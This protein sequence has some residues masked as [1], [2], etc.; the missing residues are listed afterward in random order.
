M[1][2]FGRRLRSKLLGNLFGLES[3]KYKDSKINS[4]YDNKGLSKRDIRKGL[5]RKNVGGMWEEIGKLQLSF[6]VEQGLAPDMKFLDL[7]CGSLRGGIHFINYLE[8]G[9]YYGMDVNAPL[10]EAGYNIELKKAGLTHK[11]PKTNLIIEN[12]FKTSRF[13]ILFDYALAVSVFTHLPLNHIRL[14]FIE[15]SKSMKSGGKFY[16]TFFECPDAR[17]QGA[18]RG[19][20]SK[21]YVSRRATR[22][23]PQM[24]VF[25]LNAE[26]EVK[27][28]PFSGKLFDIR[29]SGSAVRSASWS[30][31]ILACL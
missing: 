9:N 27:D 24:G 16:A 25:Q 12:Q 29:L 30:C 14:C 5:H 4:Y 10:V 6:L 3:R 1:M 11:L 8:P 18:S 23:R 17:R 22:Q 7:G 31:S 26:S 20:Y 15:L 19:A 21:R 28:Y 2:S 13:G